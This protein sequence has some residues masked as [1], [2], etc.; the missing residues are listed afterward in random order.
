MLL[1]MT[2]A[3]QISTICLVGAADELIGNGKIIFYATI[4]ANDDQWRTSPGCLTGYVEPNR[5]LEDYR[6][7]NLADV[8]LNRLP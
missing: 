8:L 4:H 1:S 3:E 7:I 6:L 5:P 2:D